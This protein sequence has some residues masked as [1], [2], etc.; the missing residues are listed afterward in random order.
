VID[1]SLG[2]GLHEL[3]N[4][5]AKNHSFAFQLKY[6]KEQAEDILS[7]LPRLVEKTNEKAPLRTNGFR[8]NRSAVLPKL[9]HE[10]DKWE[11]AIYERWGPGSSVDFTS[12]CKRI[13]TYQFPL[14]RTREDGCWGSIDLL[15][16]GAAFLPVPIELKKRKP[17]ESPLRMLVEVAAY[18][19]AIRKVWPNLKPYWIE[20]LGFPRSRSLQLPETLDKVTLICLAPEEYWCWCLGLLPGHKNLM[21]PIDAWPSFWRLIDGLGAWFD[22][23]FAAVEGRW[24]IK[25]ELPEIFSARLLDLRLITSSPAA[26]NSEQEQPCKARKSLLNSYL[27]AVTSCNRS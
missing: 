19:F 20:A 1:S 27:A 24:I 22:I 5:K 16:I 13:Q 4:P 2:L 17:E 12:N 26:A 8:L 18:G 9:T 11:R 10:E 15:G 21:F 23:H 3:G 6:S 7:N 25:S 14:Q